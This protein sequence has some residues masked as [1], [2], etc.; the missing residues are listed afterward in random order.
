MFLKLVSLL[1]EPLFVGYAILAALGDDWVD[2]FLYPRRRT[3]ISV[4]DSGI[5]F[6][7]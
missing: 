1:V 7:F 2:S 5:V 4:N 6:F 3:Y